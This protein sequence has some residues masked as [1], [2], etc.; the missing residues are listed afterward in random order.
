MTERR[1]ATPP[2]PA[3]LEYRRPAVDPTA[4]PDASRGFVWGLLQ[5]IP[6]LSGALAVRHGRRGLRAAREQGLGGAG[7]ARAA[8]I[9]GWINLAASTALLV[10]APF[11]FLEQ[12]AKA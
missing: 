6:F 4:N 7:R 5:I 8:I 10:A 9:L 1:D 2:D 3:V 12:R 11:V